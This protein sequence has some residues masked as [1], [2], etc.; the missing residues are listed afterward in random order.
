MQLLTLH[1]DRLD[2]QYM[3]EVGKGAET[4]EESMEIAKWINESLEL[5]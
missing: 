2:K 5:L 4:I 3:M 1:Y